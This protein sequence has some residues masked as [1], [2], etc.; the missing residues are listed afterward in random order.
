MDHIYILIAIVGVIAWATVGIVAI[1]INRRRKSGATPELLARL[2]AI[3]GR[4]AV[5]EKTLNDIP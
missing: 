1:V 4:L 2:D 5:V 3:D